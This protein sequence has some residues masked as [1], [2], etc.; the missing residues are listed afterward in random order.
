MGALLFD[1]LK[2]ELEEMKSTL[3]T[4]L[5][6]EITEKVSKDISAVKAELASKLLGT[7]TTPT[8]VVPTL[9]ALPHPSELPPMQSD[10]PWR[11]ATTA[12]ISE[13]QLFFEGLGFRPIEDFETF[14]EEGVLPNCWVRLK[15][16]ASVREDTVPTETVL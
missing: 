1:K 11:A 16:D 14:P 5:A 15:S 6:D 8:P 13:G 3:R 7:P 2:Q 4:K 10:N 9:G 12:P